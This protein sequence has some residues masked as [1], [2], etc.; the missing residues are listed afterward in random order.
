MKTVL[1]VSY[2][3]EKILEQQLLKLGR[4][5]SIIN[6]DPPAP[7]ATEPPVWQP[8]ACQRKHRVH[9]IRESA[10]TKETPNPYNSS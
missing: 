10:N 4:I 1:Y 7:V 2:V 9:G 8:R 3:R 6:P 5:R